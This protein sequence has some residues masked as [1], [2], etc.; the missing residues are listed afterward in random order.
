MKI[1]LTGASGFLGKHLLE[2]L[3]KND[4][5]D[6]FGRRESDTYISDLTAANIK[7][8]SQYDLIVHAAGMAHK[9]PRNKSENEAFFK[10]NEE[11]TRNF[12]NSVTN[13]TK[14]LVFISSVAVYGKNEGVG[15]E[16]SAI[17]FGGGAYADSKVNAEKLVLEWGK[18][19]N[20]QISILRLPLVVGK[21]VPGNL[22]LMK[23]AIKSGTYFRI[24]KGLAKKSMVLA[25]DVGKII[26]HLTGKQGIFNLT[27]GCHP[28]FFELENAL[29]KKESKR[30]KCIPY[31]VAKFGA[32]PGDIFDFWPLTSQSFKKIVSSLTFNDDKAKK[33]LGWQPTPVLDWLKSNDI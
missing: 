2:E 29:A 24:G 32:I 18:K 27:D 17:L 30:I 10:I 4:E 14:A 8:T 5:V 6:T 9:T 21:N 20:V 19:N 15:I 3:S 11:G 28:T 25:E 33:E 7:I 31:F 13:K 26:L 1:L 23:N 12:I 16:E 22:L